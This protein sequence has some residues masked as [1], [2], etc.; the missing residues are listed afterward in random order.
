MMNYNGEKDNL[1][2][3][4]LKNPNLKNNLHELI[5]NN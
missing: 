2:H 5:I 3:L 1:H 4:D